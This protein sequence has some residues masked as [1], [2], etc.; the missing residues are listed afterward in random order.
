MSDEVMLTVYYIR[1]GESYGNIKKS[2]G[3]VGELTWPPNDPPLTPEGKAQAKLLAE[4]L[5]RGRLDA[6]Y[7]SPLERAADTA[8]ETAKRQGNIPVILLPDLMEKGTLPGYR[9]QPPEYIKENYPLCVP[10]LS[11]PTL[12]GGGL[13]LPEETPETALER[14]KRCVSYFRRVYNAG[15]EIAVFS[16]GTYFRYFLS[17]A[18]GLP[19]RED[20]RFSCNNTGVSKFKFYDDGTAKLSFMNDTSHLFTIKNDL[21]Y[22]I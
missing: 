16:H 7:A 12:T 4:R 10:C 8:S 1:H 3:D 9:G 13:S 19:V 17:A 11:E 6:I 15:E 14:A 21:T 22:T 18:L 5:G 2:G 20:L